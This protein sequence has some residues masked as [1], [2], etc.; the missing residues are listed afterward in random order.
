MSWSSFWVGV[1]AIPALA[2]VTLATVAAAYGVLRL[3]VYLHSKTKRHYRF[4][5]NGSREG[6]AAKVLSTG[7]R[8][9]YVDFGP[10]S[11]ILQTG[12]PE[13]GTDEGWALRRKLEDM[14]RAEKQEG[15]EYI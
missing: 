9:V 7:G 11:V 1:A 5:K 3:T 14:M 12:P 8:S 6:I 13:R 2:I 10:L 4:G 15:G